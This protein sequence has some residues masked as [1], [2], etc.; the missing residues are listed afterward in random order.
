MAPNPLSGV[1]TWAY[2]L[3]D[4]TGQ[5]ADHIAATGVDMV[6]IDAEDG[7]IAPYSAARIDRVRGD[8]GLVVSYLSIGEAENYRDY[9]QAS[10]NSAP[11]SFMADAN[12]EWTDNFNVAYWDPAWQQ[13]ILDRVARIVSQGFDGLY[14]DIIDA[15]AYWEDVTPRGSFYRDEMIT[16]VE[17]IRTAA[18]QA[19][20]ANDF[21]IIGQNGEDLVE[22]P[23]YLRAV[24]GIGKEDLYFYY[25]NGSENDFGRVPSGWLSGS[26]ELLSAAEAA[27]VEV[28]TVEYIPDRFAASVSS[29]L[30]QEVS[31]LNA[32]GIPL[33]VAE[34]RDLGRIFDIYSMPDGT[35]ERGSAAVDV[36]SG[37]GRS[38]LLVGRA[39]DDKL[40]GLGNADTLIG[41][42]GSDSVYGG[43]GNDSL[44][45][46]TEDDL[47]IGS[48]GDDTL[49]GDAGHDVLKG[50]RGADTVLGGTGNDLVKGQGGADLIS[51][52]AGA[53]SL[54]G[55][56][57]QDTLKGG[58]GN[59]RLSGGGGHD[60]LI[61]GTGNDTMSGHDGSDVFVFRGISGADRI[62]DFE[63][64]TDALDLNQTL[65]LEDLS[66]LNGDTLITHEGG[67][68]LLLGVGSA[69]WD[70]LI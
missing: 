14:L 11:P 64:G 6:V 20:A 28:F 32:Q 61:G 37:T 13:I 67:T 35:V 50:G 42:G 36:L 53:D 43:D 46:G 17:R 62:K 65:G 9:W 47:I 33:Y 8:E 22:D 41:G 48:L 49:K 25:P 27:G 21:V 63:V 38:D 30:A 4:V 10:W 51:G 59:D 5:R 26:Q 18:Q 44:R 60:R 3:G 7:N 45:G 55:G 19:G 56:N 34:D 23:R 52:Q 29:V 66:L 31:W 16:F 12:P 69:D 15:Y 40:R 54:V 70:A 2:H 24:D 1:Q 58:G 39:G 57:G 68:I